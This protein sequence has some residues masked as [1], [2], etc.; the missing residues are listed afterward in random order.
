M[1]FLW[2][3]WS[4]RYRMKSCEFVKIVKIANLGNTRKSATIKSIFVVC[5]LTLWIFSFD[6]RELWQMELW[7]N[8]DSFKVAQ[9]RLKLEKSHFLW[10][11]PHFRHI[12]TITRCHSSLLSRFCWT[13]TALEL[14]QCNLC[15]FRRVTLMLYYVL[16][17]WYWTCL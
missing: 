5:F 9:L 1:I 15:Q 11:L 16:F 6:G 10:F 2:S 3:Y 12:S 4:N 8:G 14:L 13:W 7:K 17:L